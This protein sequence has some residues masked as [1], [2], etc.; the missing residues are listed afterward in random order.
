MNYL[1]ISPEQ[2]HFRDAVAKGAVDE[3]EEILRRP[4]HPDGFSSA[5]MNDAQEA[6][7]YEQLE[8]PPLYLACLS[9]HASIASLLLEAFADVNRD[10]RNWRLGGGDDYQ[11][12]E[13]RA[14]TPLGAAVVVEDLDICRLLLEGGAKPN[15]L[16][17][18]ATGYEYCN[19]YRPLAMAVETGRADI[20]RLLWEFNADVNLD[21]PWSK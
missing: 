12:D 6:D 11:E 17:G 3:V 16:S 8:Q 15:K 10:C 20:A 9:G 21:E 4:E 2:T 18:Y 5:I 14:I 13:L 7:E 1:P 19:T